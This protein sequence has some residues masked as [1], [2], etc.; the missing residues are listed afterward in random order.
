MN[1]KL[2]AVLIIVVVLVVLYFVYKKMFQNNTAKTTSNLNQTQGAFGALSP[3]QYHAM[4]S[5][6]LSSAVT[7]VNTNTGTDYGN[8]QNDL[9]VVLKVL[10]YNVAAP[11]SNG[12]IIATGY[13]D[14]SNI[15]QKFA[16][17]FPGSTNINGNLVDGDKWNSYA[18]LT[19]VKYNV[20]DNP[21]AYDYYQKIISFWGKDFFG[22]L[23][24]QKVVQNISDAAKKSVPTVD[25]NSAEYKGKLMRLLANLKNAQTK[26]QIAVYNINNVDNAENTQALKKTGQDVTNAST[27]YQNHVNLCKTN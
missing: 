17:R 3:F 1:K 6:S 24:T 23:S 9:P 26:Y 5:S 16:L 8:V 25:C 2:L 10:G 11:D 19:Y 15:L 18:P 21:T 22:N 12:D 13:W 14:S 27:A 20:K 4:Q 7:P